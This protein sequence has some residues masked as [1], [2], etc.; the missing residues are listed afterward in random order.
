MSGL[1]LHAKRLNENLA[2]RSYQVTVLTNKHNNR[3]KS[4]EIINKVIVLR[5]K[6]FA[7]ISKGFL[8]LDFVLQSIKQIRNCDAVIINL[9][10]FEGVITAL[11]GRI[12]GK[13]VICIYHCEVILPES[14]V[15]NW[16]S[17]IL[18]WSNISSMVLSDKV[19]T[20]TKDFADNSKIL[21]FFKDKISYIYPPVIALN[22]DKRIKNLFSKKIRNKPK[23]ILGVAARLA[24]EKGLEYLFEAIADISEKLKTNSSQLK[25]LIA[26]SLDPVGEEKYKKKIMKL[27]EKF[28]ENIIFFDEIKDSDMGSFYSLLD[29]LVLPSINSTEAFG[30]V[31]IE[32]MMLGVPVVA[33]NLPGVRVAIEKTGMGILV[34][35]KNP[36]ELAEAIYK[37]LQNKDKYFCNKE[38]ILAEFSIRKVVDNYERIIKN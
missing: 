4:R 27:V 18:S 33:S 36:K 29:V 9:P 20:Y 14:L 24:S 37:V 6:P 13:K 12:F 16:I 26:G 17:R 5:S 32:A 22:T 7:K 31:Q 1:S 30:M 3:L 34:T 28:K 15:N 21:S 23:Y 38:N 2:S 19:V 8:S 10:Q 11:V 25:I 35:P